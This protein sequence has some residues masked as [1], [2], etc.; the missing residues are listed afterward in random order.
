M[1]SEVGWRLLYR[2][3]AGNILRISM[4]PAMHEIPTGRAYVQRY[5]TIV[6]YL[7]QYFKFFI[8]RDWV[9]FARSYSVQ[10]DISHG[11][12]CP[13]N[14]RSMFRTPH[15]AQH[16]A[17]ISTVSIITAIFWMRVTDWL[18][19]RLSRSIIYYHLQT[20]W[21]YGVIS[22]SYSSTEDNYQTPHTLQMWSNAELWYSHLPST[23]LN[24]WRS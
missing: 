2:I 9:A 7:A 23:G 19:Y 8:Y 1:R 10:S 24:P 22:Y 11:F 20:N 14:L 4:S 13:E 21:M 17:Y 16:A 12:I 3:L 15:S 6:C 18:D 5:G